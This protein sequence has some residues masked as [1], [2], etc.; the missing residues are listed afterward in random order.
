MRRE[1]ERRE[2][3]RGEWMKSAPAESQALGLPTPTPVLFLTCVVIFVLYMLYV[4]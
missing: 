3:R 1:E 2:E 4:M